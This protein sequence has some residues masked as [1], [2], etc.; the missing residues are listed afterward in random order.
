MKKILILVIV[1][2]VLGAVYFL[3]KTDDAP[4][5]AV[6]KGSCIQETSTD[7]I[8]KVNDAGTDT[9][10]AV[11]LKSPGAQD[12]EVGVSFTISR[13]DLHHYQVVPCPAEQ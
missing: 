1:A 3:T 10:F 5:A 4:K 7:A 2:V 9:I 11:A 6:V 13:L 12:S 8:F